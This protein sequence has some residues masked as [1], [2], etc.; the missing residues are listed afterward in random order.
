MS[1][2]TCRAARGALL[3][4]VM[5]FVWS[6]LG[7]TAASA[8]T[9]ATATYM[10]P[11]SSLFVV[12]A[13]VTSITVTATGAAGGSLSASAIGGR[14]ATVT[15]TVPVTPG[16]QLVVGVGAA[17]SSA[18][19]G[20][21]GGGGSGGVGAFNGAGGGGAS[22][23]SASSFP[24]SGLLVVAGGG[25][26]TG[27]GAAGGDA[28]SVGGGAGGGG[29]GTSYGGGAGGVESGFNSGGPGSFGFGGQ[30]GLGGS[31]GGGGGG[32]YYGG[33]GGAGSA[34][35]GGGG[36][37]FVTQAGTGV[38]GPT[39][40]GESAGVSIT[41]AAPTVTVSPGALPFGTEPQGVAGPQQSLTLTNSGAADLVVSGVSLG[42]ADPGDYLIHNGCREPV[43]PGA[44]CQV[45][46]RFA[47]QVG[48]PSA[49]TLTLQSNAVTAPAAVALSGTGGAL[50][51][52]PAGATGPQGPAGATGSPGS[53]GQV[54]LVTCRAV[55]RT[56]VRRSHGRRRLVKVTRTVCTTGLVSGPIRF[57]SHGMPSR[58]VLER[59][60]VRVRGLA[61][62][63][64]LL[65]AGR[66]RLRAGRY[67]LVLTRGSHVTRRT[68]FVR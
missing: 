8:A 6:G 31:A 47:P 41:Y 49:A 59:P 40:T 28:G 2:R 1:Q 57:T 10:V 37:S 51:Q 45:G 5:F 3:T 32:G 56:V 58:A 30:G 61:A 17:G 27:A 53:P 66:I 60:G 52:G 22:S 48:G 63:D 24:A 9:T 68:V 14:G 19:P 64:K 20:G 43:A 21:I 23:V 26:G 65:L 13:G 34:G 33:G 29:A 50:P 55:T 38:S 35:G 46:V 42:G 12:P 25:G 39:L 15:A 7:A 54:E 36:S 4:A 44:S 16:E 11:G 62:G 18:G 67:T